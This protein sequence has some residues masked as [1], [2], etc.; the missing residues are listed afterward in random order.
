MGLVD[1][2]QPEG[3]VLSRALEIARTMAEIPP[4]AY[5]T[6]K[7]QVR[8]EAIEKAKRAVAD[9]SDPLVDNWLDPDAQTAAAKV[10]AQAQGN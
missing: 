2:L 1:E 5:R 4:G 9:G 3:D 10:L 8:G 6:V 7:F